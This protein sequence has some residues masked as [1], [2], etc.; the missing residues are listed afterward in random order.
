MS[1]G[2]AREIDLAAYLV[3]PDRPEWAEFR[4]HY[5]TCADC[6]EEVA[7]WTSIEASLRAAGDR[8]QEAHPAVELL[9]RFEDDPRSLAPDEWQRIDKHTRDCRQC[10]DELAALREFDFSALETASPMTIGEAMRAMGQS[11]GELLR[12]L[13][14]WAVPGS[15]EGAVTDFF[16]TREPDLVFQSREDASEE[17]AAAKGAPLAVLVALEGEAAGSA[18][19]VRA[20]ESRI[21]RAKACEIQIPSESLSRAEATI[22]A[23]A[24]A[25]EI[26]ALH[27]RA[28]VLVNGEPVRSGSLDDGD[29]LQIGAE[30]FQ[31]RRVTSKSP[32]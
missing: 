17:S 3:E 20:G 25:L 8:S 32:S 4:Q 18:F 10:A 22:R 13:A 9:A 24:N 6:A 15:G 28:A 27:E 21:G 5:P 23:D 2:K 7:A 19:A 16:G 31:I 12:S 11:A 1:C 29:L 14:R 26:T 30:R